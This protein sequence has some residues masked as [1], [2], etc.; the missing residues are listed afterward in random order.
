ML[1]KS[2]KLSRHEFA[3]VFTRPKSRVH[4]PEYSMY[5][6]PSPAFKASVVVA[7]KV[8]KQAVGRNQLRREVYGGLQSKLIDN[9]NLSGSYIFILKPSF[10]QLS[11]AKRKEVIT[12]L[13]AQN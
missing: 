11:K 10:S 8:V 2:A 4:L 13:L 6:S 12:G 7:K 5:Y 9:P 3:A 1:P